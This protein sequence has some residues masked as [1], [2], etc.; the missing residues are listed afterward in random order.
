MRFSG[1]SEVDA[2]GC[3][4]WPLNRDCHG[5]P[6]LDSLLMQ[7]DMSKVYSLRY[8]DYQE[9]LFSSVS[10]DKCKSIVIGNSPEP[11]VIE[12]MLESK[13]Q[14]AIKCAIPFV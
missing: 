3:A 5:P 12:D 14:Y 6:K 2:G 7:M 10:S 13:N 4:I 1:Y 11:H 9:L 8:L